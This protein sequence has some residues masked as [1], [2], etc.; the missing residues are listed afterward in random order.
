VRPRALPNLTPE[1]LELQDQLIALAEAFELSPEPNGTENRRPKD[2]RV[3]CF[4]AKRLGSQRGELDI[5]LG[6]EL[7]ALVPTLPPLPQIDFEAVGLTPGLPEKSTI[8]VVQPCKDNEGNFA[9]AISS[10]RFA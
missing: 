9:D 3:R 8:T 6:P 10:V 5:R 1:Q 7:V 2:A 4:V